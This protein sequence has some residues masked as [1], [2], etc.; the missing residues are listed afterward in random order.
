[1]PKQ[2]FGSIDFYCDGILTSFF[3]VSEKGNCLILDYCQF[4]S[5]GFRLILKDWVVIEIEGYCSSQSGFFC[6][7]DHTYGLLV[8]VGVCDLQPR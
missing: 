8:K 6:I 4:E 7:E 3:L 1:M 2:D 5:V